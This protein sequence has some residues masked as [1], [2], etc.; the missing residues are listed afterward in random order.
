MDNRKGVIVKIEEPENM[1]VDMDGNR[2]DVVQDATASI[3]RMIPGRFYEHYLGS[4]C[5]D[6]SKKIMKMLGLSS[7][8]SPHYIANLDQA[9]VKSTYQYLLG[10]YEIVSEKMHEFYSALSY[11][12]MCE[13]LSDISREG[14]YLYMPINNPR[15]L[16]EVV[17]QIEARY[18][19]TYGPVTYVGDSG[20]RCTTV[21][22]VRIA[23]MYLMLLDKI[24]DDWSSVASGRLQHFGILT[25]QTKS[26][27]FSYPF[28]NSPVR[29]IGETE[30]RIFA[31]YCGREAF[32][33]MMDRSNSPY[34]QRNIVWNVLNSNQ[35]T[36]IDH[37]I[38]RQEI[39]IGASKSLALV[40]HMLYTAGI[41][42][43]YETEDPLPVYQ[44]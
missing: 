8:C 16:T 26:E 33:E 35:P 38:N 4:A 5:R 14:I 12:D 13:H 28:R 3:S 20:V 44:D 6:T 24:A 41:E 22:K 43:T 10:F 15:D 11:E 1:P 30:G 34:A 39:P 2:A 36:N 29:T 42:M 31:G 37:I 23:P 25:P 7:A 19:P 32:A 17:R 40:R 21:N 18:T 9:L 27:K